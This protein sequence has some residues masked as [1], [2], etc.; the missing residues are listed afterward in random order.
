[1]I[2]KSF[3]RFSFSPHCHCDHD[4]ES[5]KQSHYNEQVLISEV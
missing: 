5:G 1:M 4:E 2:S 3:G